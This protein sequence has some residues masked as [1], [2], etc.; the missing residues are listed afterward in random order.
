MKLLQFL[1]VWVSMMPVKILDRQVE[2]SLQAAAIL[3]V[4]AIHTAIRLHDLLEAEYENGATNVS[5]GFWEREILTRCD[6]VSAYLN[7]A[8]QFIEAVLPQDIRDPFWTDV[9]N[10]HSSLI[11]VRKRLESVNS[12][13]NSDFQKAITGAKNY[14]HTYLIIF[15]ARLSE[16][17]NFLERYC[18]L[19]DEGPEGRNLRAKE[20]AARKDMEKR[21]ERAIKQKEKQADFVRSLTIQSK[22]THQGAGKV[23]FM[24]IPLGTGYDRFVK[25]LKAAGFSLKLERMEDTFFYGMCREGFL[26]GTVDGIPASIC[27][28][29]SAFTQS[30]YE[31]EVILREFIDQDEAV[32]ESDRLMA[33]EKNR[34]P[35]AIFDKNQILRQISQALDDSPTTAKPVEII[36]ILNADEKQIVQLMTLKKAELQLYLFDEQPR[37][38]MLN[39]FGSISFGVYQSTLG[40][41][42]V[43][44]LRYYD[45]SVGSAAE[46][47]AKEERK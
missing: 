47:E 12:I 39:S 14:L 9:Y 22:S 44:Q 23:C 3:N 43:V 27:L 33:R 36:D 38:D 31:I 5:P 30:V 1:L 18:Q 7:D 25:E 19:L 8:I 45:R 15:G 24:G 35:Y 11:G 21:E 46:A 40:H 16:M 2:G 42:H 37:E 4:N 20:E 6:S 41:E 32:E 34:Y 10:Y 26:T 17:D 29:A 28:T 13:Y